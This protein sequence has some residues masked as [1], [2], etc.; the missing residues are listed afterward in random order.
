LVA[1]AQIEAF[2]TGTNFL[3]IQGADGGQ[4]KNSIFSVSALPQGRKEPTGIELISTSF[5]EFK[6]SGN[7]WISDSMKGYENLVSTQVMYLVEF[8]EVWPPVAEFSPQQSTLRG[9]DFDKPEK[10]TILPF[11]LPQGTRI[12]E[13][14][15]IIKL[16]SSIVKE[17]EIP[18]QQLTFDDLPLIIC[19][20]NNIWNANTA[21]II[22]GTGNPH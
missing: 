9:E 13:G 14:R 1:S 16:N 11:I 17:Y 8:R 21:R 20:T 2:I 3:K 19:S 12:T 7:F 18:Q 10:L 4:S 22:Q 15:V 6:H 5:K